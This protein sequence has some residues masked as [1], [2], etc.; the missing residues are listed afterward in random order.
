VLKRIFGPKREEVVGELGK[1]QEVP[2]SM[3]GHSENLRFSLR[4][5]PKRRY[6]TT[7]LHG[8]NNA[9]DLDLD[10]NLS[11]VRKLV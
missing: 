3:N 8:V 11:Y 4:I 9:E 1:L 2:W 5:S 6:P 10:E 7:K